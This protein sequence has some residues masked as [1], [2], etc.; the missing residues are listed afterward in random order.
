V[1][2]ENNPDLSMGIILLVNALDSNKYLE[3]RGIL[4]HLLSLEKPPLFVYYWYAEVLYILK[5]YE[6]SW[7]AFESY[8]QK[9][10]IRL[11]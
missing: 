11:Q 9:S 7:F 5:D 4:K 2:I 10:K 8:I 6:E 3:A 1:F